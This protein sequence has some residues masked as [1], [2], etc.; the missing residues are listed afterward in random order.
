MGQSAGYLSG[1]PHSGE[2]YQ[3]RIEL[4]KKI[5]QYELNKAA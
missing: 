4:L 1:T 3:Q 2:K 5:F